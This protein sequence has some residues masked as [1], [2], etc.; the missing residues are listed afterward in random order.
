MV[1]SMPSPKSRYP[2]PN[3]TGKTISR[4]SS[5]R[6]R[7]ISSFTRLP[8]PKIEMFPPGC[9]FCSH[10]SSATS[11]FIR[12][13]LF[14]PRDSSPRRGFGRE[15][16]DVCR[17]FFRATVRAHSVGRAWTWARAQRRAAV[18]PCPLREPLLLPPGRRGHNGR[19]CLYRVAD[20]SGASSGS[21]TGSYSPE[22]LVLLR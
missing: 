11:P 7:R 1:S 12:V 3:T 2:L 9:P 15:W 6:P 17:S 5:M 20:H 21:R 13:E 14:Y 18:Y 8:L 4:Y 19:I 16:P 22:C 10:T